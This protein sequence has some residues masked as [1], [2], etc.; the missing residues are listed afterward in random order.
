MKLAAATA[1]PF[2]MPPLTASCAAAD[3]TLQAEHRNA[4]GGQCA[5]EQ[6]EVGHS[7]AQVDD[8]GIAASKLPQVPLGRLSLLVAMFLGAPSYPACSHREVHAIFT[9][10][11]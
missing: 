3:A 9:F 1:S 6:A 4:K 10:E 8:R 7:D 11:V 2:H 5:E